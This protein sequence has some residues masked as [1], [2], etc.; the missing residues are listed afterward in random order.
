[1]NYR[2]I[3]TSELQSYIKEN[4]DLTIGQIV[5]SIV[6]QRN[7]DNSEVSDKEWLFNVSDEDFYTAIEKAKDNE[8][9]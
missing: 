1:M 7:D 4:T 5:L 3:A 6:N 2:K 8:R 9:E